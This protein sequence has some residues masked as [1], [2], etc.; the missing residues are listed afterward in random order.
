[1]VKRSFVVL[2]AATASLAGCASVGPVAHE[3]PPLSSLLPHPS[4]TAPAPKATTKMLVVAAVRSYVGGINTVFRT[5]S[6]TAVV[7]ATTPACTC[8]KGAQTIA[9]VYTDHGHYE[10]TRFVVVRIMP[11]TLRATSAQALLTYRMP[12]SALVSANGKRRALKAQP[13][14]TETVTLAK[15]R[16]R[17]LVAAVATQKR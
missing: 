10:D 5:G 4:P 1:V 6:L 11:T 16:G 8:R 17:W 3:P 14:R 2:L 15:V 7:A 9:K 13:G 12:A